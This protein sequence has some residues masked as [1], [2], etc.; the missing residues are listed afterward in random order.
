MSGAM[1]NGGHGGAVVGAGAGEDGLVLGSRVGGG[2]DDGGGGDGR[3]GGGRGGGAQ[4]RG[5]RDGGVGH[6]VVARKSQ[7]HMGNKPSH[8][9]IL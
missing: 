4:C 6:A 8:R 1:G 5:V 7:S 2:G 9:L 3:D